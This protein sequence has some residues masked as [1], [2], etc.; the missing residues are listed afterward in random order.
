MTE[1]DSIREATRE[2]FRRAV[3]LLNA[4]QRDQAH[5]AVRRAIQ[6]IRTHYQRRNHG[7]ARYTQTPDPA[8]GA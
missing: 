4:G 3:E 2:H 8:Q 6:E 7:S 5:A 1:A